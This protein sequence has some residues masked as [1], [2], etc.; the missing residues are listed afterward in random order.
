MSPGLP[1]GCQGVAGS[2]A[3]GSGEGEGRPDG[4]LPNRQ[5]RADWL[6]GWEGVAGGLVGVGGAYRVGGGLCS[7]SLHY[8]GVG[9]CLACRE[10]RWEGARGERVGSRESAGW[11]RVRQAGRQTAAGSGTERTRPTSLRSTRTVRSSSERRARATGRIL[12]LEY[13]LPGSPL[14][15]LAL[16]ASSQDIY[17]KPST[18][19]DTSTLPHGFYAYCRRAPRRPRGVR[20]KR[21]PRE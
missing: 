16:F 17:Y 3:G 10:G 2:R 1:G 5:L 4:A 13:P 21:R 15:T 8:R 7:L 11:E 20:L 19:S 9:G 12:P 6:A 14:L 18:T